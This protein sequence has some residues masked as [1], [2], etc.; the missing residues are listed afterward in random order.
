MRGSMQLPANVS[1]LLNIT[2]AKAI[3]TERMARHMRVTAL[4]G[5]VSNRRFSEIGALDV[6]PINYG[7][8][9]RSRCLGRPRDRL[10]P[11]TQVAA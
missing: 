1:C 2:L 5:S 6:L 4:G 10:C 11:G 8:L 7:A 3:D 9:A